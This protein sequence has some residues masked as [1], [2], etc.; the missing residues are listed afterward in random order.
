LSGQSGA[1]RVAEPCGLTRRE[2][3]L[4]G[5]GAGLFVLGLSGL[6]P[7]SSEAEAALL[8][9]DLFAKGFPHA[10]FFRQTEG[11]ARDG[12]LTYTEWEK[13]YLPLD[14]IVGKV[15][16]EENYYTKKH[17][18]KWFLNYKRRNPQK[19]VLLHYNG[20]GRR[21]T[22]E[23][24]TRFFAG[25]FLYYRGTRLTRGIK[26]QTQDVLH[27]EDTSVFS[28]RRY[29]KGVEDDIAIARVGTDGR[30]R[31]ETAE[32][33]RLRSIDAANNTIT[34]QRGNYGTRAR[35]FPRGSYLAAHVTTGPYRYVNT[36][37]QNIP[38]WAY[39]FS[40]ECPRDGE[41]RNCG[42]ALADYL[43]EKLGTGELASFDGI[44]LDVFSWIIGFGHPLQEIDVNTDGR[45]DRGHRGWGEHGEQWSARLSSG[46]PRAA[47]TRQT[48]TLR[49]T[50]TE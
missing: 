23:A 27:V 19:M 3:L 4:A 40:T 21:A 9:L 41:G 48:H 34:V 15:L 6:G 28:M 29:R 31:W 14:G 11:D 2:F 8:D 47:W 42:D 49:R 1:R 26:S 46:T 39:N 5:A 10:F 17:N 45:A 37:E 30:P 43:G 18:L 33:V 25:H 13:R 32:Q 35:K 20:T 38:L 24:T 36:P 44:T 50:H 22:D 12:E 7:G 16:N